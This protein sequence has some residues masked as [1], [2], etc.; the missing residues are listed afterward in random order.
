MDNERGG[1]GEEGVLGHWEVNFGWWEGS[2]SLLHSKGPPKE[3]L[4]E[5]VA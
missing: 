5:I 4:G 3:A 1:A 2:K